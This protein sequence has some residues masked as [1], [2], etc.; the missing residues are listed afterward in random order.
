M[1]QPN[2]SVVITSFNQAEYLREALES[3]IQQTV[4][5][6]Q[7]IVAD[8]HSTK[9]NSVDVIRGY[10][11]RYPGWIDGIFHEQNVSI[12][13]NRNSA[14]QRVTGNYV[15]VLDGDDRLLPNF[16]AGHLQA[17][18]DH[19]EAGC[20][21]SNRYHIDPQGIRLRVRNTT[22]EP[23][24]DVFAYIAAT[25]M[26]VL[27]SLVARYDLIKAAGFFDE[28]F[29]HH[30]GFILTLRLAR[31]TKFVHLHEPLMEKRIH[32][33]GFSKTISARERIRCFEDVLAEVIKLSSHLPSQE[34]RGIRETWIRKILKLR[35]AK[36]LAEGRRAEAF[37][38]VARK[39]RCSRR[40][41]RT[42][43]SAT[44]QCWDDRPPITLP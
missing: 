44:K 9:D 22:A 42:L 28:R 25:R 35:V 7:V 40:R 16:I 37:W 4:K 23:S 33:S 11:S 5:P 18:S 1:V 13:K 27:R 31:L 17:L 36:A 38:E 26:G 15:V 39:L 21:Y 43:W 14:L 19:P 10:M 24:G 29:I 6:H 12:P 32:T 34:I 8:D 41:M 2:V 3:V 30:D 20:S